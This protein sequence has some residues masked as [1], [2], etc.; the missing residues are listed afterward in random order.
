VVNTEDY[1]VIGD[2]NADF[3][4]GFNNNF[5]YKG[6]D[7]NVFFRFSYGN[8]VLNANKIM[9]EGYDNFN[10]NTNQYATY[11]NRWSPT[12]PNNDMPTRAGRGPQYWSTRLIE[13]ASMLRLG[14]VAVG[15]TFS[16]KLMKAIRMESIRLNFAANNLY[17]WTNYSGLDPE[18]SVRETNLT[19][20]LDYSAYPR[21]RTITF[22][23]NATF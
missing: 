20:S 16:G 21:A 9:F 6:F 10:Y 14:V 7:L 4:G 2:P 8:D 17:T 5:E 12:N 15:Y 18:V 1:T 13:D 3:L 19:P 23:L 22:G 11:A